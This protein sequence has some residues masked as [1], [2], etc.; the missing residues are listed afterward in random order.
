[1]NK[2]VCSSPTVAGCIRHL[3]V[4]RWKRGSECVLRVLDHVQYNGSVPW[5]GEQQSVPCKFWFKSSFLCV[6]HLVKRNQTQF[7]YPLSPW[8]YLQYPWAGPF[9][10]M[11]GCFR[12]S[13]ASQRF[14][15]QHISVPSSRHWWIA[16][17]CYIIEWLL[18]LA[19]SFSSIQSLKVPRHQ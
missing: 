8:M 16:S 10:R 7:N 14:L 12:P 19:F 17:I 4:Q 13:S 2:P 9:E 18:I 1:M 5:Q 15:G 6:C 3:T 11:C